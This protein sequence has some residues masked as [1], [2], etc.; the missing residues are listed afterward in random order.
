MGIP[1]YGYPNAGHAEYVPQK[2][3]DTFDTFVLNNPRLTKGERRGERRGE[4]ED[5]PNGEAG[6]RGKGEVRRGRRIYSSEFSPTMYEANLRA[7][8]PSKGP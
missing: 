4:S 2:S 7:R 3:Y 6:V 5:A 1:I 8:T